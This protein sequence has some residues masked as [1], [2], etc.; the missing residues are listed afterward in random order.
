MTLRHIF[1]VLA[2]SLTACNSSTKS[3]TP[4]E[5]SLMKY[6]I[7]DEIYPSSTPTITP[8]QSKGLS[9]VSIALDST[10]EIQAFFGPTMT[11]NLAK[12]K[13][14]RKREILTNPFFVKIIE[15]ND[16]GFVYE[17]QV[18][19]LTRSYDFRVIKQ[20]GDSELIYQCGNKKE[21]S[22]AEAKAMMKVVLTQ[23]A[24]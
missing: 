16:E 11:K 9:N 1:I 15:E 23:K 2:I 19:S 4:G 14:D 22:E 18:D 5:V 7:P 3:K 6:G 12:L 17:K 13:E 21:Y 24:Q 8:M 10:S 20:I